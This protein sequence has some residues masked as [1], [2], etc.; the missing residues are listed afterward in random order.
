LLPAL[1]ACSA[2][3]ESSGFVNPRLMDSY[4]P[5]SSG[6]LLNHWAAA[7]TIAPDVAVTNDHNMAII[8]P[9]AILARSRD[10]DLLFFRPS[11]GMPAFTARAKE[12]EDVIAYGQGATDDL[13]E[14]RG[15]VT[16]LEQYVPPRCMGCP[17]QKALV[18][19]ADAGGGFSGG[20]VVDAKTG[21]VVGVTFG[22]L[23][24]QDG[25]RGRLM[26]AYDID[27]V[28]REMRR[29]LPRPRP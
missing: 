19:A 2:G 27:L 9:G 8:P 12:G 11:G 16:A 5:L 24:G 15:R 13:R 10:Y 21:A 23:D 26:Y 17:A 6:G 20:P 4:I 14:A 29:L 18:F 25:Q 28:M 22:Y 7:V 3:R 1:I